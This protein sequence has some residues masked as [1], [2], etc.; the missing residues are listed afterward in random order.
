MTT[1]AKAASDLYAY[2]RTPTAPGRTRPKIVKEWNVEQKGELC[3]ITISICRS[4]KASP[5]KKSC[6]KKEARLEPPRGS[7]CPNRKVVYYGS[8]ITQGGCAENPGLSL[9]GHR[10]ALAERGL[11]QP[12]LQRQRPA[13]RLRR[14]PSRRSTPGSCSHRGNPSPQVYRETMPGFVDTLRAKHPK[15]PILIPGPYY[16]VEAVSPERRRN[17]TRNA[18]RARVCRGPAQSGR[19]VHQ[20]WTGLRCPREHADGPWTACMPTRSLTFAPATG[21]AFAQGAGAG[22]PTGP[23]VPKTQ[24]L[25]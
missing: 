22:D 21:T 18:D 24:M 2:R 25:R 17:R 7:L 14:R 20:L 6:W 16:F 9:P 10:L 12:R 19:R 5:S 15:T 4:T 8:S 3:D 23:V 13:S 11:C 1:R